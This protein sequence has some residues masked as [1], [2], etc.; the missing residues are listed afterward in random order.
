TAD[1]RESGYSAVLDVVDVNRAD[2]V[3]D[4]VRNWLV[5]IMPAES[6]ASVDLTLD[7]PLGSN[8]PPGSGPGPE[9]SP[10]RTLSGQ[11]GE[12]LVLDNIFIT[13]TGGRPD[14]YLL[15]IVPKPGVTLPAGLSWQFLNADN[16]PITH[17]VTLPVSGSEKVKLKI[18][19]PEDAVP[20]SGSLW[21]KAV[22]GNRDSEDTLHLALSIT[23]AASHLTLAPMGLAQVLPGSLTYFL[24]QLVNHTE[25]TID[26]VHLKLTDT[27]AGSGWQSR[28]YQ[29]L[30]GDGQLSAGDL[31]VADIAPLLP[32]ETRNL[33]VQVFAPANA[34]SGRRNITTLTASWKDPDGKGERLSVSVTDTALV[35]DARVVITKQQAPWDCRSPLP[36][37]FSGTDFPAR[38]D[39]CVVYKLTAVNQGAEPVQNLIIHDRAPAFTRF[40]TGSGLP[41]AQGV[42]P[43][44]ITVLDQTISAQWLPAIAPGETVSLMFGIRIY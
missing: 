17:S 43:G 27:L 28:V 15:T 30:D 14:S 42:L 18:T 38:P 34:F 29:D 40:V 5:K 36:D 7:Q 39:T 8:P 10:L 25:V 23:A 1:I 37:R 35:N 11:P 9:A 3:F 20:G 22:S 32:A 31:P 19:I 2:Q 44:T 24:H 4:N 12:T 13:N 21:L 26:I 6:D 33:V 41:A 16:I